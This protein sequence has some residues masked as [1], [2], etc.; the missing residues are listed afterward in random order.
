M[1]TKSTAN[2]VIFGATGDL[3]K[4]MLLPSLYFLD[5]DGLLPEKLTIVGAARSALSHADF[6]KL[7]RQSLEERVGGLDETV[8]KRFVKRLHYSPVDAGS[9]SGFE[10]LSV[11]LTEIN[12]GGDHLFFL[13]LSPDFYAPVCKGLR[14]AGL[15]T[16]GSR[17]IVEKPIG[18]DLES[19]RAINA[20]LTNA[21]SEDR[22]FRIDHYLGKETV[23]NLLALRF[24][25]ILFEPLWNKTHIDHVEISVFETVGVEGRWGYYDDYG[26][27]RDMVQNH[28]LQ[29]LCLVAL[30]PPAKLNPDAVR[31]EKVK[32]LRSLKPITGR[33][34]LTK[35][36]R[37][38]YADGAIDGQ[39]VPGYAREAGGK[40]SDTE[41]FVALEAEIDNWRWS[42]VPF[43]MR[44]GKRIG[45]RLTEIVVQFRPVPHSVFSGDGTNDLIPN[46]LTITLQPE[47]QVS[48]A[49]M[50]KT[51]GLTE[52]GW[53]MNPLSLNLSL[54]DAF[55]T[56]RRRI[57]YEQLLLDA[58]NGNPTLFVRG[59][60]TEAAWK[61]IDGIA[62]GW[63]E[64][65]MKPEPYWA[66]SEGPDRVE[67][68]WRKGCSA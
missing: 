11:L 51:P 60:E 7:A 8:W 14:D 56:H 38:Q 24:A 25:N 17:I 36:A 64:V 16:A 55:K 41:T 19:C 30:E 10:A 23:Q 9:P 59:D 65:R 35:T 4:R 22:I 62:A 3:A 12:P 31:D 27:L 32:V 6:Q 61:W 2:L 48:L 68:F 66:G 54:T 33:D 37:G 15:A 52:H 57:A 18:H 53:R 34:V 67:S 44:T 47:E 28:I 58:L 43:L 49:L 46:R 39:N 13:S 40:P 45:K 29:L 50:N 63:K 26:A 42:G 1:T 21:F 20:A 5:Q